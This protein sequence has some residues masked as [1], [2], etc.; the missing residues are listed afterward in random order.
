M[1]CNS[2]TLD[3]EERELIAQ[4]LKV[5]LAYIVKFQA[6]KGLHNEILFNTLERTT[7]TKH[8]LGI[9]ALKIRPRVKT[10]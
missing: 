6:S 8:K 4:E 7:Q 9:Y 3:T 5:K 10:Y 1:G 2:S